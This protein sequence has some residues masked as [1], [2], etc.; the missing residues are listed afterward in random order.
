MTQGFSRLDTVYLPLTFL[1][2]AFD[3]LDGR[4]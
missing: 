2:S 3:P 1:S 4:A